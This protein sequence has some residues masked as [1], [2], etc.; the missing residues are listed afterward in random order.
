MISNGEG[1]PLLFKSMGEESPC[2]LNSKQNSSPWIPSGSLITKSALTQVLCENLT[3][4]VPMS[5]IGFLYGER[6]TNRN[7]SDGTY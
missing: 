1:I 7:R 4:P 3:K 5:M 6:R 2:Y